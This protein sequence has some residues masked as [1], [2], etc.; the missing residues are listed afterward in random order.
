MTQAGVRPDRR[1]DAGS[2]PREIAQQEAVR[3]DGSLSGSGRAA[4]HPVPTPSATSRTVSR[5]H[6]GRATVPCGLHQTGRQQG[7]HLVGCAGPPPCG[8]CFDVSRTR[9]QDLINEQIRY[10]E[11]DLHRHRAGRVDGAPVRRVLHLRRL[12]SRPGQRRPRRPARRPA[13]SPSPAAP[14]APT[15]S[16]R[17]AASTASYPHPARDLRLFH[18]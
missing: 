15:R 4:P 9:R 11:E 13:T 7:R 16:R 14:S 2:G 17:P 3:A 18:H 5:W 12:P 6:R 8:C 1:A 10:I